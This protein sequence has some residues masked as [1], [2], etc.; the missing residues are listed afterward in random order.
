MQ[1]RELH[2]A[3]LCEFRQLWIACV[4]HQRQL[5]GVP[6]VLLHP[7]LHI[8]LLLLKLVPC[9]LINRRRLQLIFLN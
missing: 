7:V 5:L 4:R 1:Q 6:C 9:F 3:L 8:P 2:V